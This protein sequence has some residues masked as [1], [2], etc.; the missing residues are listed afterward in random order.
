[1]LVVGR[2]QKRPGVTV[3]DIIYLRPAEALTTEFATRVI[4]AAG[5]TCLLCVPPGFWEGT[6]L[7]GLCDILSSDCAHLLFNI[8]DA[9][10]RTKDLRD[11][12]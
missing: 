12:C 8:R 1:M 11:D 10:L 7:A 4:S 9:L 2:V 5:T 6:G 3:G